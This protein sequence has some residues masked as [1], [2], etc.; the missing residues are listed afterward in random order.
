MNQAVQIDQSSTSTTAYKHFSEIK[1]AV[2]SAALGLHAKYNVQIKDVQ[3]IEEKEIESIQLSG[4]PK[5]HFE[6][7]QHEMQHKK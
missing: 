6:T 2:E 5:E 7:M 4:K 3:T 1:K